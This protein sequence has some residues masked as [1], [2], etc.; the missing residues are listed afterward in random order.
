MKP[1]FILNMGGEGLWEGD[2]NKPPCWSLRNISSTEVSKNKEQ[3][4]LIQDRIIYIL[5]KWKSNMFWEHKR[6][7]IYGQF[8]MESFQRRSHR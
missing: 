8:T 5:N 2:Q 4:L 1:L 7:N 3:L 6:R